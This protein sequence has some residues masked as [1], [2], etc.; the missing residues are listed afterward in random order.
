[1][2]TRALIDAMSYGGILIFCM[3]GILGMC[4]ELAL[5]R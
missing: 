5:R 1:M 4:M 3:I 2:M